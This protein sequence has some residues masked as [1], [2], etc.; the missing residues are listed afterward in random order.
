[1]QVRSRIIMN[2]PSENQAIIVP[3]PAPS[4]SPSPKRG[5]RQPDFA[6]LGAALEIGSERLKQYAINPGVVDKVRT[7]LDGLQKAER[8]QIDALHAGDPSPESAKIALGAARDDLRN[9]ASQ[10]ARDTLLAVRML[11]AEAKNIR[12][13]ARASGEDAA[14]QPSLEAL[15][16]TIRDLNAVRA[17]LNAVEVADPASRLR[18]PGDHP[19]DLRPAA[20]TDAAPATP[21]GSALARLR[22]EGAGERGLGY[23]TA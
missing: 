8:A 14:A 10:T 7:D 19:P 9:A 22:A 4:P 12:A 6:D 21:A 17:R 5:E 23:G 16:G 13:F 18:T 20:V 1:M 2:Q 11:E 15:A 3:V